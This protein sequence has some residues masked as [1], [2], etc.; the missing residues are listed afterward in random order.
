MK[1]QLNIFNRY[2]PLLDILLVNVRLHKAVV[3]DVVFQEP[4]R[5][6]DLKIHNTSSPQ[7]LALTI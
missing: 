7:K 1:H 3:S 5:L 4:G 6:Y 2:N